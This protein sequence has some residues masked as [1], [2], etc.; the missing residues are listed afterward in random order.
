MTQ[1]CA[2]VE[3]AINF[4]CLTTAHILQIIAVEIKANRAQG[5]YEFDGRYWTHYPVE[6]VMSV[7]PWVSERAI[8]YKIKALV[9]AGILMAG[10]YRHD[11]RRWYALVDEDK[12]LLQLF[13]K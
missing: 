10:P 11:R 1:I 12:M 6:N 7:L 13:G 4:R 5:L 3:I 9:D 2:N 8:R